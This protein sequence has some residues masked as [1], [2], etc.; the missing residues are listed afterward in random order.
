[1][2]F[3]VPESMVSQD[4]IRVDD[5]KEFSYSFDIENGELVGEGAAMLT[6]AISNSH[7]FMLGNNSRNKM[8]ADLELAL[9]RVLNQN[10]Y[11]TMIMEVGPASAQIVNRMTSDSSEV[12]E[13]FK[14]LNQK[15]HFDGG[16]S[17]FMPIPDLKYLGACQLVEYAKANDWTIDGI[18]VDYWVGYEMLVDELYNNLPV[19]NQQLHHDSYKSTSDL[20]GSLLK[21]VEEQTYDD[22]RKLILSL[23]N[24]DMF[25]NYIEEMSAYDINKK[26][27]QYFRFS[28]D[29]WLMYGNQ[30]GFKKNKLSDK[31]NKVLMRDIVDKIDFDFSKDKMFV[32]MWRNHLVKGL[33]P[34]G[35]YGVGNML[36]ELA[37]Y[38]GH[39]SLSIGVLGRYMIEEDGVKDILDTPG[40]RVGIYDP[41]IALGQ[42]DKWVLIDL[43][44][45]TEVFYWGN[46]IQTKEMWTMMRR[47]DMII[48]PKADS[49]AVVNF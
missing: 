32:K 11:K 31:R 10:N 44:P 48:I 40:R 4:S 9:S 37:D 38:H 28:L 13:S 34:N 15:Y 8:E 26:I 14:R 49:K 17:Q 1:M 7:L 36:M 21:S 22:V 20:V 47:Y 23:K 39:N 18:G 16:G 35:N 46:Y 3:A 25:I 6:K 12:V 42:K 24:S 2:C 19:A 27:V 45:F 33:T 41:L 29:Y 43:R 30:E 5:I